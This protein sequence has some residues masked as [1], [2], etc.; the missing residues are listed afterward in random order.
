[1]AYLP[2]TVELDGRVKNKMMTGW[3]RIPLKVIKGEHG[4]SNML[5]LDLIS[6]DRMNQSMNKMLEHGD[7]LLGPLSTVLRTPLATIFDPSG[8]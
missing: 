4:S 3:E 2:R 6:Y 7:L 1:M 5:L 8:V